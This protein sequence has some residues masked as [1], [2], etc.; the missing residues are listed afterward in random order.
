MFLI[1]NKMFNL[2]YC[3]SNIDNNTFNSYKFEM[4]SEYSLK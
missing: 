1:V 2:K 4:I 3:Y